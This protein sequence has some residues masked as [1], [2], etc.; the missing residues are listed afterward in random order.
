MVER[1][2]GMNPIEKAFGRV[3]Q[4]IQDNAEEAA[5]SPVK[6]LNYAFA[7][8]GTALAIAYYQEMLRALDRC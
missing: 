8:I 3:K 7:S 5:Y 1:S 6:V 2:V 4:L